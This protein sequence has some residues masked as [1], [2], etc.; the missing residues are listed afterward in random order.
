M[1]EI[2]TYQFSDLTFDEFFELFMTGKI[3]FGDY[4]VHLL[5][6]YNQKHRPNVFFT[7]YEEMKHDLKNVVLKVAEFLQKGDDLYLKENSHVLEKILHNCSFE[8][9][10]FLNKII[11]RLYDNTEEM[12]NDPDLPKGRK[13]ILNYIE[14]L[15]S[16]VKQKIHFIR[17][18]ESG[19]WRKVFTEDQNERMNEKIEMIRH[20]ADV[21]PV[22][23]NIL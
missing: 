16:K 7:T 10:K 2:P 12:L 23:E 5:S 18:G 11:N 3:E 9:M 1:R 13:Y 19:G 6:W 20:C 8:E 21:M 4:F 15:P 14:E 22:W 17:K